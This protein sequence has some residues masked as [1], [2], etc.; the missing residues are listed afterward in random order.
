[1]KRTHGDTIWYHGIPQITTPCRILTAL[2]QCDAA[3]EIQQWSLSI[4]SSMEL[5]W[6]MNLD[7]AFWALPK[8]GDSPSVIRFNL[9]VKVGVPRLRLTS[10]LSHLLLVLTTT[11]VHNL[12]NKLCGQIHCYHVWSGEHADMVWSEKKKKKMVLEWH[13]L[14]SRRSRCTQT[15]YHHRQHDCAQ[16]QNREPSSRNPLDQILTW[17]AQTPRQ[18]SWQ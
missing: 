4:L 13:H 3:S 1:M 8:L 6:N 18:P 9:F 17:S 16:K 5:R 10:S 12:G 15:R 7:N 11:V 2:L 14:R